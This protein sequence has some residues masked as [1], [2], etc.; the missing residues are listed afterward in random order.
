MS[1]KNIEKLNTAYEKKILNFPMKTFIL[2]LIGYGILALIIIALIIIIVNKDSNKDI[3][4]DTEIKNEAVNGNIFDKTYEINQNTGEIIVGN[5]P[6]VITEWPEIKGMAA[7]EY[8]EFG[9]KIEELEK[10]I[11]IRENGFYSELSFEEYVEAVKQ[12]YGFENIVSLDSSSSDYYEKIEVKMDKKRFQIGNDFKE[13][14][15]NNSNGLTLSTDITG[16]V[17]NNGFLQCNLAKNISVNR[18][19]TI[20]TIELREGLH[21]SDGEEFT[22]DDCVFWYE[23]L[24]LPGYID[25]TKYSS[26]LTTVD[27]ERVAAKI[28]RKDKYKIAV[29]FEGPK[30]HFVQELIDEG[31]LMYASSL[32]YKQL[33]PEFIGDEAA[34]LLAKSN[35]YRTMY[36]MVRDILSKEHIN[37]VPTMSSYVFVKKQPGRDEIYLYENNPYYFKISRDGYQLPASKMLQVDIIK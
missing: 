7:S 12:S 15:F 27:G 17:I 20:Y 26:F 1:K 23:S 9:E 6:E 29:E 3:D 18:D 34:D 33:L 25:S 36:D 11:P 37:D 21:W 2:V 5:N 13:L 14:L 32:Y 31:L 35:G 10:R 8:N 4:R 28:V 22:A 30:A 16:S 19:L 24:Y